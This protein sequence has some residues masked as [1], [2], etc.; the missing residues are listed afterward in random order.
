MTP[1][2]GPSDLAGDLDGD[3]DKDLHL[4][5][6]CFVLALGLVLLAATSGM[7]GMPVASEPLSAAQAFEAGRLAGARAVMFLALAVGLGWVGVSGLT[8]ATRRLMLGR[9]HAMTAV[10]A[11]V[12]VLVGM[13]LTAAVL[14]I[15]VLGLLVRRRHLDPAPTLS[16]IPASRRS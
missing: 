9:A 11:V 8:G 3:V 15:A 2:T 16:S 13:R 12:S 6:A 1:P 14:T 5:V 4:T 10:G 7:G